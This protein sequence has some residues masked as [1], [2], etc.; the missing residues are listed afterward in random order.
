MIETVKIDGQVWMAKDLDV[1]HFRNGD[2]IPHAQSMDV[3]NWAGEN[4][5]PAWRF[6]VDEHSKNPR[7]EN[8][9][10]LY[11]W[12][13]VNDP[14][15]LAP[16]GWR[17]PHK[18]DWNGLID[19]L[20]GRES[21]AF[22]LKSKTG[23]LP[24]NEGSNESNFNAIAYETVFTKRDGKIHDHFKFQEVRFWCSSESAFNYN[25]M[26]RY[27]DGLYITHHNSASCGDHPKGGGLAVRCLKNRNGVYHPDGY[28]LF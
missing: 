4:K 5:I 24:G 8:H 22:K 27:A 17:I 11:N 15:G 23:W 12:Y 7:H 20:G 26:L 19:H 6:A 14:R 2:V 9:G 28:D 16:L 18:V 1:N 3:W 10:K 13:A 25:A 21:A